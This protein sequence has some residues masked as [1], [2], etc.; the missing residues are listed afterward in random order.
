MCGDTNTNIIQTTKRDLFTLVNLF[1][2]VW[3]RRG[4]K[5]PWVQ[6]RDE[7]LDLQKQT[8][9][10]DCEVERCHR[11][12]TKQTLINEKRANKVKDSSLKKNSTILKDLLVFLTLTAIK[13]Q[14]QEMIQFINILMQT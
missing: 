8:S 5:H 12:I 11:G 13:K 7:R 1:E 9:Q 3:V 2:S 10:T 14:K 6:N 4:V